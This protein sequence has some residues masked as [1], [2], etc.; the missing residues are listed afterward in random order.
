MDEVWA[1]SVRNIL[2]CGD[3]TRQV[4]IVV[5]SSDSRVGAPDLSTDIVSI[6][7]VQIRVLL[8]MDNLGSSRN[9]VTTVDDSLS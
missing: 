6:S 5:R 4:H 9:N 8:E 7:G 1:L 2:E 3:T